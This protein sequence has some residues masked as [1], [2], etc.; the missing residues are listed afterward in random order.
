MGSAGVETYT[1]TYTVRRPK[2]VVVQISANSPPRGVSGIAGVEPL[3]YIPNTRRT[4]PLI[5]SDEA[6]I[7]GQGSHRHD[8][9]L[10]R[11]LTRAEQV[12]LGV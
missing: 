12:Q 8:R 2:V 11:L 6:E 7:P 9:R 3:L 1:K 10:N 4:D 5:L